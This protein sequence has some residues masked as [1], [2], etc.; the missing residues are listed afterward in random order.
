[1]ERNR[2]SM[3][4]EMVSLTNQLESIK[5]QLKEY[6]QLQEEYNVTKS[7]CRRRI[8]GLFLF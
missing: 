1:M 7:C 8:G 6:P 2:E 4:K 5:D 3:A